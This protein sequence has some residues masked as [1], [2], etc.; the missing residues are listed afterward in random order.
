MVGGVFVAVKAVREGSRGPFALTLLSGKVADA[1]LW[2]RTTFPAVSAFAFAPFIC[3][4][5]GGMNAG[6]EIRRRGWGAVCKEVVLDPG[7]SSSVY[8]VALDQE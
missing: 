4:A 1:F 2:N 8:Q 7:P 6:N 3:G 5:L